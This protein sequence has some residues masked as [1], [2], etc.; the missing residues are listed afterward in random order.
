MVEGIGSELELLGSWGP[1]L[2]PVP[3]LTPPPSPQAHSHEHTTNHAQPDDRDR[4]NNDLM[5]SD[6]ARWKRT[7]VDTLRR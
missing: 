7:G 5:I 2:P 6:S 4:I 3:S 1:V